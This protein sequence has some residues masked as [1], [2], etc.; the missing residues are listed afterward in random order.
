M[1]RKEQI[2]D[3][4]K[5]LFK[6]KGYVGSSMRDLAQAIGIE[7]SSLYNH[8]KSKEE[9]LQIICFDLADQFLK[10]IEEVNAQKY[11]NA[12][13]WI[14]HAMLNHLKVVTNNLEASAVF[15]SEWRFLTGDAMDQYLDFR[16]KYGGMYR[17]AIRNGVDKGEFRKDLNPNLAAINILSTMNWTSNWFQHHGK[18]NIEVISKQ[19]FDLILKGIKA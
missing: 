3:T 19:F 8:V 7:A 6:D 11:S 9:L 4:A 10:A 14:R 16:K 12:S 15:L 18:D 1:N 17:T 13:D 5:Q 2:K